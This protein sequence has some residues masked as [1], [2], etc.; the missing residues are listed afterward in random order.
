MD[1][2]D[3]PLGALLWHHLAQTP[4]P[5]SWDAEIPFG[6]WRLGLVCWHAMLAV[7]VDGPEHNRPAQQARDRRRDEALREAGV[8]TMRVTNN[9]V[10]AD[11]AGVAASVFKRACRR[12][13]TPV[14]TNPASPYHGWTSRPP[15]TPPGR[16]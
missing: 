1:P 7:E 2:E 11:P 9:E 4:P 12:T 3:Q 6:F 14:H 5:F 16:G 10:L 8:A 13:R 15:L